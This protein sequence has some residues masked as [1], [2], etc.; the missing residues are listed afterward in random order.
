MGF[1]LWRL[2]RNLPAS[3]SATPIIPIPST[4]SGQALTFPHQGGRG[5]GFPLS[6]ENGWG[7]GGRD[8][9]GG[10]ADCA[11]VSG[12]GGEVRG[13]DM[14]DMQR[15]AFAGGRWGVGGGGC[16]RVDGRGYSGRLAS[17]PFQMHTMGRWGIGFRLRIRLCDIAISPVAP[18][19]PI[20][21]F[22]HQGDLCVTYQIRPTT[23]PITLTLI[24]SQDGRGDKRSGD[25]GYANVS[26]K[27]EEVR[28]DGLPPSREQ[29]WGRGLG[30]RRWRWGL[31]GSRCRRGLR[32]G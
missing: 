30:V 2:L 27:G 3:P 10:D 8:K 12:M 21:I 7:A 16:S 32:G 17:R 22:P 24:L 28:G 19:T 15:S 23:S 13:V 26:I 11:K 6:R 9:K 20:S 29:E 5:D 25:D 1:R 18:I 14:M 31:R 4:D